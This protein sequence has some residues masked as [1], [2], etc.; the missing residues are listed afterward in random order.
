MTKNWKMRNKANRLLEEEKFEECLALCTELI[1]GGYN[2]AYN[3][4]A[5]C[6]F[7]MEEWEKAA[8][9]ADSSLKARGRFY[10]P[11][12]QADW[13]YKG[14]ANAL[15]GNFDDALP[16]LNAYIAEKPFNQ[17][18]QSL[19]I[20]HYIRAT[21]HSQGENAEAAME[22]CEKYFEILKKNQ[23]KPEISAV[24]MET[25]DDAAELMKGLGGSVPDKN[26]L[27][28]SSAKQDKSKNKT[29][30]SAAAPAGKAAQELPVSLERALAKLD[31][32][33]GLRRVKEEVNTLIN[34]IKIQKMREKAGAPAM[35]I[36]FHLVFSGSPGTGK[37]TV[38]RILGDIYKALEIL[39]KGHLVEV[40]RSKLV[41]GYLGQTAIKTSRVI[42][43]ALGG[44]L[45]IDE[46]YSLSE[47][48]ETGADA[49]GKEAIDTLLKAMEDHRDN[50]IIITAGYEE[51]MKRF[52]MANPGLQSRFNTFIYFDDFSAEELHAVFVRMA[53]ANHYVVSEE[54]DAFLKKRFEK[55]LESK[56]DNF[57]NAREVRNEFESMIRRKA[58]RLAKLGEIDDDML[59]RIEI[60][61][62]A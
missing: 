52:L 35:P 10:A 56:P 27:V 36:S 51:E 48:G 12:E 14:V 61:D 19:A 3:T 60:E 13:W 31:E 25:F 58:N 22:D 18:V 45:F 37:T 26:T 42:E 62:F 39:P 9:D 23:D 17:Q 50:L 30:N 53:K 49:F 7:Q 43:S 11:D 2:K 16:Y 15:M 38:A 47:G 24:L 54:V 59:H 55:M 46:A 34:L 44:I 1:E 21:I 4:R 57:A 40:D 8:A 29:N 6:Y 32:L 5:R 33:T 20:A 28:R 41:A